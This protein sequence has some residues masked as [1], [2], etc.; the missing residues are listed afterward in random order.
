[1][2]DLN[3]VVDDCPA[4]DAGFAD[5]CTVHARPGLDLHVIFNDHS[6]RLHDFLVA[7]VWT[8]GEAEPVRAHCHPLVQRHPVSNMG[9]M[10]DRDTAVCREL[11]A[12]PAAFFDDHVGMEH[13]ASP[14]L[15]I[16]F[17]HDV[18]ADHSPR[19]N[20]GGRVDHS[21]RVNRG[22]RRLGR[23]EEF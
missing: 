23:V 9:V 21:R 10:A 20:S 11:V 22:F 17:Y 4:C 1:M 13:R 14:N 7:A 16:A 15:D 8:T 6:T 3:Q 2:S 18:W 5:G 19:A 12:D